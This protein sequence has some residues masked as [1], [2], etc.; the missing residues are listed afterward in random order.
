MTKMTK[1]QL[2][3]ENIAL[4]N[5]CERLTLQVAELSAPS[6]AV[7]TLS[8]RIG[9]IIGRYTKADGT[10]MVKIRSGRNQCIH[11]AA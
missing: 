3:D 11:R 10:R 4:R 8:D 5:T 6:P 1:A 2:V 9:D 7:H